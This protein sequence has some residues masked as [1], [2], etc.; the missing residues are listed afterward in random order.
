MGKGY[1]II[2][3]RI[4][5]VIGFIYRPTKKEKQFLSTLCWT[6]GLEFLEI[7]DMLPLCG[8]RYSSCMKE[9]IIYSLNSS[10]G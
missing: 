3:H 9:V 7:H 2:N 6:R 8:K 4:N 1:I 10:R 5:R